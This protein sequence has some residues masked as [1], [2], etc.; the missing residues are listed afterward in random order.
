MSLPRL[1]RQ[2]APGGQVLEVVGMVADS[3]LVINA[4]S[5]SLKFSLFLV[6][7]DDLTLDVRGQIEAL[8]SAP[9]FVAKGPSGETVAERSWGEGAKLSHDGA[10]QHLQSFL[11]G[12]YENDRVVGIGHRVVHGGSEYADPVRVDNDVLQAL[13]RLIPLAP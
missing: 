9:K 11:R 7:A 13:E 12:Q 2:T 1:T 6:N 10:V 5:S 3:I 8:D 4:G